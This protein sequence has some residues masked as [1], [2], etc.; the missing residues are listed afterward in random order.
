M[1]TLEWCIEQELMRPRYGARAHARDRHV[2]MLLLP[3]GRGGACQGERRARRRVLLCRVMRLHE[4]RVE[5]GNAR[6]K[7]SRDG[8]D[9]FERVDTER[10]IRSGEHGAVVLPHPCRER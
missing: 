2:A 3:P 7:T 4:M 1:N 6:K 10:E 9:P 5:T 8:D